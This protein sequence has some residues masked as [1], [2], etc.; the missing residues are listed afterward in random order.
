MEGDT[1]RHPDNASLTCGYWNINGHRSKYL[2]DKLIDPEF[3]EIIHGCDIVGL[4]EIQAEG[5]V[6]IP[7]FKNIKQKFREKISLGPK[8]AGGLG[9]FIRDEI[10]ELVEL[11]PN[12]CAD[13]I[14]IKIKAEDTYI[15]TYYVSP[16]YSKSRDIDFFTTLNE[17]ISHFQKRGRF[18]CREI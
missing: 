4:G 12:S 1:C 6:D 17:E 3:I 9:V 11:V 16:Q 7:G 2:G 10:S 13:S 14:W 5:I 8:I 15:G 18:S